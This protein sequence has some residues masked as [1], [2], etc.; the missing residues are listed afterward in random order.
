MT[1]PTSPTGPTSPSSAAPMPIEG[2]ATPP[3]LRR[4]TSRL[5]AQ[6]STVADRLATERLGA[7]GAHKWQV[8]VL[9]SLEAFGPGS[10]AELSRRTGIYRSDMVAVLNAL[11]EGG[12]VGRA[13]DPDDKRRNVITLTEA[14]RARLADLEAVVDGVQEELLAPFDRN[15]REQL[16]GLLNRFVDYHRGAERPPPERQG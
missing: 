1:S 5:L 9:T 6:S 11:E 7:V 3:R 14:G 8:A 4:V 2:R 16:I 12:Y 15:E 13:P 10:Q